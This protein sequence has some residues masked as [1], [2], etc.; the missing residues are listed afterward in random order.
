[1]ID[2]DADITMSGGTMNITGGYGLPANWAFARPINLTMGGGT[3]NLPP[4]GVTLTNTGNAINLNLTGGII[5]TAGHFLIQR[6]GFNPSGG[7]IELY[8][9]GDCNVGGISGSKFSTLRINKASSREDG[10][11][12]ANTANL[13][14]DTIVDEDLEI[15]SGQLS[16]GACALTVNGNTT[17]YSGI[18]MISTSSVFKQQRHSQSGGH[19]FLAIHSRKPQSRLYLHHPKRCHS[20]IWLCSLSEFCRG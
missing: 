16:I 14:T 20:L 13:T 10:Q 8:G 4:Q 1:V 5:R 15:V 2:L 12:R 17:V 11:T 7:I 18:K 9:T 3:L 19:F 6:S